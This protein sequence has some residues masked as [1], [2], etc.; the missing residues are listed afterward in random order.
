MTTYRLTS[1]HMKGDG[2]MAFQRVMH[3]RG[4][5]NGSIDGDCGVLTAQGFYR[6]KF[7]LGYPKPDHAGGDTLY[8]YLT[9]KKGTSRPMKA[10][11]RVR[12]LRQSRVKNTRQKA[13]AFLA[14][15]IGDKE[16]PA[17]S[18]RISWAS[19]WYGVIGPWCAMAVTR[20][21]VEAGSK[22]FKRAA[23]YAY[24]PFVVQD[25]RR[26]Q[27]HLTITKHPI[28]GDLPC[29]DWDND[30][31][32]DHIGIFERWVKPGVEFIAVEGNTGVGNDS[33]GGEVMR[34]NRSVRDVQVFVHVGR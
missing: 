17:G 23:R 6:S 15:R 16:S 32:A 28:L 24:V 13:H 1:P 14:A 21:Y 33:N 19:T 22:C 7:W 9:G 12:R 18:N 8:A 10:L 30:G 20:A 2:V 29:Y 27:N 26:G 3:K 31:I 4:F 11:A 5:Y 34:R 25:G